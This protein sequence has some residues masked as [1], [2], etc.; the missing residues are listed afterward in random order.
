MTPAPIF[1]PT[2]PH[3]NM[4]TELAT[5]QG[6]ALSPANLEH[7]TTLAAR[8]AK[9]DLL[10]PHF[11]GR[12]ENIL[13]VLSLA[14]NLNINPVMCLQ[15]VSVIGGKP[16][17]QATLMISLLNNS[18]KIT[19]PLRFKWSGR[20]AT[21]ERSCVAYAID[22]AT[23]E[24]VESEP[25][26]LAMAQAEGWTRNAKYKSIPDTMLKWRAAS[27]FVRTYY[28]Q[29]VLGLHST[30]ELDDVQIAAGAPKEGSARDRLAAI[31]ASREPQAPAEDFPPA[32]DVE[33]SPVAQAQ[34][35]HV[36]GE[37]EPPIN[38]D[39]PDMI[40]LTDLLAV[41]AE[42]DA[43]KLAECVAEVKHLP[44][45]PMKEAAKRAIANRR[46]ALNLT[47]DAASKKYLPTD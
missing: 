6:S 27:F 41:V 28:P 43:D 35:P 36:D 2:P 22:A 46:D 33:A 23:G 17:L 38:L 40:P 8:L 7:T 24:A 37:A 3:H 19:G 42:A 32:V 10:P 26:S 47:W 15:Q 30:E 5:Y 39:N 21:P 31:K 12:P 11:K 13:L 18:G 34:E 16:C 14:Q 45:A 29:V 44:T 9:S 4:S 1:S 20:E 25:V